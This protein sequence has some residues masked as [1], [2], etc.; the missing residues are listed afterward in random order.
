VGE[1]I[2]AGTFTAVGE[3]R[4]AAGG[5]N[6]TLSPR[7]RIRIG[8]GG[9]LEAVLAGK[10]TVEGRDR[11]RIGAVDVVLL[12][13]SMVVIDPDGFFVARGRIEVGG[14]ILGPGS[15]FAPGPPIVESAPPEEPPAAEEE[16]PPPAFTAGRVTDAATGHPL[17]GAAVLATFFQGPP[18][19]QVG[20][21]NAGAERPAIEEALG[22]DGAAVL[23][24]LHVEES[25]TDSDGTFEL[26][27]FRPEDPRIAVHLQVSHAGY[28]PETVVL[29]GR[30]GV[31]GRWGEAEVRL[32]RAALGRV[33]LIGPGGAPLA[34]APVRVFAWREGHDFLDAERIIVAGFP[35]EPGGGRLL[36]LEPPRMLFTD[37]EGGLLLP[38]SVPAYDLELANT[39]HHLVHVDEGVEMLGRVT[40]VLPLEGPLRLAAPA[41]WVE[42]HV[43]LDQDGFVVPGAEVEVAL[44][45]MPPFRA[46]TDGGGWFRAGI[47]PFPQPG[48]KLGHALPR[49]GEVIVH[50][51]ELYRRGARVAFPS[52]AEEVVVN[53]RAAGRIVFRAVT[54]GPLGPEPVPPEGVE[55]S[56]DGHLV[57]RGAGGRVEIRAVLPL[58][59]TPIDIFVAGFLP[60]RVFA[61]ASDRVAA[62]MDLGDV[63]FEPGWTRE[64]VLDGVSGEDLRGARVLVT[65]EGYWPR[66]EARHD[67]ASGHALVSGLTRG[68]YSFAVEGPRIQTVSVAVGIRESDLAEPLVIPVDLLADEEAIVLGRV[69]EIT[70]IEAMRSS[71]VERWFLAG[72][73]EPLS[74]PAYPLGPDGTFGSVRRLLGP[75]AVD[76]SIIGPADLAAGG[77]L[78]RGDG[79]PILDAGVVRL[80]PRT[81]AEIVFEARGLGRVAPPLRVSLIG[82]GGDEDLSRLRVRR[83]K[84]Y[85]DNLAPGKYTLRWRGHGDIEESHDFHVPR[86]GPLRVTTTAFR[87]PLDEETIEILV[88]DRF[89]RPIDGAEIRP[90]VRER[91]FE[92]EEQGIL[93]ARVVPRGTTAFEV[94]APGFLPAH[95]EVAAGALVP[96]KVELLRGVE[97][98]A[99]LLDPGGERVDGEVSIAWAPPISSPVRHGE[100]RTVLVSRGRFEVAGLPPLPLVFTLRL[101]PGGP[102]VRGEWTLP[103][104]TQ[105][106]DLGVLRFEET[107]KLEGTVYLPDGTPA[108]GASVAIVPRGAARRF[109]LSDDPLEAARWTVKSSAQGIFTFDGLPAELP[110]GEL[111]LVARFPGLGDAIEDP[112]DPDLPSHD[113]VLPLEARLEVD[114]GYRDSAAR[115]IHVPA[116][117]EEGVGLAAFAFRLEYVPGDLGEDAD[118]RPGEAIPL[119]EIDPA[120][121]P[122]S[123]GAVYPGRYRVRWGLRRGYAPL[124]GLW[125]DALVLPGGTARLTARLE[126]RTL[127][128]HATLNGVP[129]ERGWVLL[130][131]DPGGGT[132]V[133]RIVD[134]EFTIVDPPDDFRAHA[135]VIPERTPQPLQNIARG[136][137]LPVLLRGYR[138]DARAGRL[139]VDCV[140][141]DLTIR[142]GDD[143]LA[144][145]P[146]AVIEFPHYEWDRNRFRELYAEEPIEGPSLDLRLLAPGIRR[147]EVRSAKGTLMHTQ[148]VDLRRDETIVI[149]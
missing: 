133:G 37:D 113:L 50:S 54:D 46:R 95:V 130:T 118:L 82:E 110:A 24:P 18:V 96:T 80:G 109:P 97:A 22:I 120:P 13:H 61:F 78:A 111:A 123:F 63:L 40:C 147:L 117:G 98:R 30:P 57:H 21:E 116:E 16:A 132:H 60:R 99:L 20:A 121:G 107:R 11:L 26:S 81:H 51:P 131:A 2:P 36:L 68:T 108:P 48:P 41:S 39:E 83:R 65:P 47:W 5:R 86:G 115:R 75:A 139:R 38:L 72:A 100:P 66:R 112:I 84:L 59:G 71:V 129:V 137:A 85:A 44:A 70:P 28:G 27:A 125:Q 135:A 17:G 93:L 88:A 140:G 3:T 58:P 94:R 67:A 106:F 79:P 102:V 87:S 4:L 128:G 144:R 62:E 145:H 91:G 103:E 8:A 34:G 142:F 101:E 32:R 127:G 7:S 141:Y 64:V 42:S 76:V 138:A 33:E 89:G 23:P 77:L 136:E 124:P 9:S 49:E 126:G 56:L 148:L 146:G 6:M 104:E 69:V 10:A 19:V 73:V 1:R 29:S 52:L 90:P 134:G 114:A 43:L 92:P 74:F 149:R 122:R 53:G 25:V 35:S 55:T 12:E 105:P 14:S 15:R 143:F 31:D 45:G 119:G